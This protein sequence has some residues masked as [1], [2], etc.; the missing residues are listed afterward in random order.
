MI[1]DFIRVVHSSNHFS[2]LLRKLDDGIIYRE[3][4]AVTKSKLAT[5]DFG[6]GRSL[7]DVIEDSPE[8]T[9]LY[10]TVLIAKTDINVCFDGVLG[11]K[12]YNKEKIYPMH[13]G[14]LLSYVGIEPKEINVLKNTREPYKE[15]KF[16]VIPK[17]PK[18]MGKNK[19]KV[20][21]VFSDRYEIELFANSEDEAKEEAFILGFG[22]WDH[23]YDYVNPEKINE[24]Q[25]QRIRHTIWHQ[26]QAKVEQITD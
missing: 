5:N 26:D 13:F 2:D 11:N 21:I 20:S 4:Y 7:I 15:F 22:E 18:G 6:E 9:D 24:Y 8:G 16:K 25:S 12:Y 19:Y 10:C 17:Q 1:D 14:D 23:I 3:A